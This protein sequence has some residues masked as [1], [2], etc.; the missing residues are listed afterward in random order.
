MLGVIVASVVPARGA[1]VLLAFAAN[2]SADEPI[3][4]PVV[5]LK[6]LYA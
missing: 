4:A 1:F 6:N 3:Y 2:T 5:T